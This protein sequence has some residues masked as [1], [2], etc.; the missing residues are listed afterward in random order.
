MSLSIT[1]ADREKWLLRIAAKWFRKHYADGKNSK[2]IS[3]EM[4]TCG[5]PVIRRL[6]RV[7]DKCAD[8]IK[9]DWQTQMVKEF[10]G[11]FA[12]WIAYKDTAYR[13]PFMWMLKQM[14]D[15]KD[16]LY[17]LVMKYYVEPEDWYVNIWHES[18]NK[19]KRDRETGVISG[20]DKSELEKYFVP[21]IQSKR[22]IQELDREKRK[23]G[24]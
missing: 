6:K 15:M 20:N 1:P 21:S 10:G 13:Q 12:L 2:E 17:P 24:L 3:D 7:V 11:E 16:E 8:Y 5:N 23:R 9:E 22:I 4:S 19:T 14:L 18:K